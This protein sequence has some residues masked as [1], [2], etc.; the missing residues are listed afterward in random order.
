MNNFLS[1]LRK[2]KDP[3]SQ[4][5]AVLIRHGERENIPEGTFGNEILLTEKGK[6]DSTELGKQLAA[7]RI[8]TIL[9]SPVKRCVQT[10]DMIKKGL[11]CD[12]KIIL[13]NQLGNPGFHIVN[14]HTAGKAFIDYGCFGVFERF[15]HNENTEGVAD[16]NF[17]RTDAVEWLYKET[18]ENGLTLFITHD[19]LIAH[20]AFANNIKK[21]SAN[22]WVDFLDG[23]I[24]NFSEGKTK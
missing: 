20:F 7:Y 13:S 24:L 19:S 23:I 9:T 6:C 3:D 2:I 4:K 16:A 12:V 14:G 10:A 5:I 22:D 17:L 1:K 18:Q 21:Y 15:L 8:N 11:G